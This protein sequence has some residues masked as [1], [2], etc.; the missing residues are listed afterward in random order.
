MRTY[1]KYLLTNGMCYFMYTFGLFILA[2]VLLLL[3]TGNTVNWNRYAIACAIWV[4]PTAIHI[5]FYKKW[6]TQ[7]IK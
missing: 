2:P 1:I 4:V 3:K 7:N 5:Y 6:K